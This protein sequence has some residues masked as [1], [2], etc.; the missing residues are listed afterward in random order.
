VQ[1]EQCKLR[2]GMRGDTETGRH[3]EAAMEKEEPGSQDNMVDVLTRR[4]AEK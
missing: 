2:D 4:C 1:G 3:G